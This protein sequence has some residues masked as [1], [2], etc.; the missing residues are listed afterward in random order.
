VVYG[1][2][3]DPALDKRIESIELRLGHIENALGDVRERLAFEEGRSW[4]TPWSPR[5]PD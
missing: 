2:S 5:G 3:V 1:D 4:P